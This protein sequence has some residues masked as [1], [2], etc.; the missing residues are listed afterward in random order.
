MQMIERNPRLVK[1]L[2][3]DRV[4]IADGRCH[5]WTSPADQGLFSALH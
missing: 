3:R 1:N 5:V 2:P 4:A